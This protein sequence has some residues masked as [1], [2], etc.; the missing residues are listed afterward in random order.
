[1][2]AS[3][4]RN[5]VLQLAV[6][7]KLVP[8][9]S[10]DETASVLLEKIKAQKE[11][12][13]KGKIKR[14]QPLPD[15]AEEEKPFE[16]PD[17]W[18]WV[19][20]EEI[21]SYIQRGKSPVYS[22]KKEIPVI[23]QKC[24]QCKSIE[25]EKC[26]FIDPETIKKYDTVRYLQENDL[27]WNSTGLGTLGRINIFKSDIS[28]Y[29]IIVADSHVTVIRPFLSHIEAKY[30]LYWFS[31]PLVQSEINEKSTG[32]TKQT[33]LAT[34]T[35]KNYVVPLPPLAEQQ[36]I[37]AKIEEIMPQINEYEKLEQE[38][39]LL[40]GCFPENLRKSVLQYAVQ[41]KL[42]QQ[43][44][45]DEPANVLVAR[46]K[47]DKEKLIKEGKLK[48]EKALPEI[49]EEEKP[50]DIPDSWEWV[51]LAEIVRIISG[52]SFSSNDFFDNGS[53][54]SIKITNVGVGEFIDNNSGYLPIEFKNRYSEFLIEQ[55]DILIA[56]TRPFIKNGLKVCIC[57][58][59]H[60]NSLL[61]QRVAA[62]KSIFSLNIR[63]I[64]CYLK[65]SYVLDVIK[66]SCKTTNQPNLSINELYSLL[67]PL[68]PLDEQ[69]RIV[70][71]V[72]ELMLLCDEL[73]IV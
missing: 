70:A 56:L 51:R 3:D 6:Q 20:L 61:N 31:G 44:S 43:D 53:V 29:K 50:F 38:L 52:Y 42:V 64:Y 9:D 58:N 4:L 69:Q 72:E 63:Y 54:K 13:I 68:P 22:T 33:E 2:K 39:S 55:G 16:I 32:S 14:E 46:I 34:S 23:A 60:N 47:A 67:V 66:N 40:E 65:C 59:S 26:Q 30:L 28:N 45:E 1:V 10:R 8:Q 62:L 7:G 21:C 37:V 5:A 19:R 71:K 48:R 25:M 49:S 12:L 41:G 27:L 15:I 18:K 17:S 57:P 24:V 11:R 35:I 36:R 73:K